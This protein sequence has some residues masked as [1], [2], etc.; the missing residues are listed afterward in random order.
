M[1]KLYLDDIRTPQSEGWDIV[2]SYTQFCDWIIKNGLPDIVSFDHDL[3]D[4]HYGIVGDKWR[5]YYE[6]IDRVYT[7]Y[8]CAK[9]LCN[10]CYDNGLPIPKYNVHSA[11][12]VG[13]ENINFLIKSY[14]KQLNV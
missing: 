2:R 11:N 7:G 6:K 10:Y 13:V 1:K 4:E 5:T 8:D 3:G 9:F 12:S 14:E